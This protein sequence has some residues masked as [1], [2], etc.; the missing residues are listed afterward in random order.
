[1]AA[2]IDA[3]RQL[4]IVA[5]VELGGRWVAIRGERA[6]SYVV[7]AGW[8]PSFYVWCDIPEDRSVERYRDSIAAVQA[9]LRR[10]GGGP[11]SRSDSRQESG[12]RSP[13]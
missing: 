9:G 6:T 13:K 2:L 11:M 1:M 8:G 10:A 5:E 7:E 3:L 4:G 12:S